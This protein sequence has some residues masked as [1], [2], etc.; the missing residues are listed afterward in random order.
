[1]NRRKFVQSTLSAAALCA[2]AAPAQALAPAI[3]IGSLRR[4]IAPGDGTVLAPGDRGY[5][6]YQRYAAANLRV[7]RSPAAR[8]V[9]T[10]R[11]GAAAAV[12]WL[13]ANGVPFSIRGGGHCYEDF[14]QSDSVVL[15]L[16]GL[17][18][19]KI[20]AGGNTVSVGA[21][22][23][24][25]DTYAALTRTGAIIPAGSC[26]QV[27]VAGHVQGG[28]YGLFARKFGLACDSLVGAE[29]ID[30][31][32]QILSVSESAH[33]DLFWA[34]RGGGG[35]SFGVVT[36]FEFRITKI[37]TATRF[38]ISWGT[39]GRFGLDQAAQTLGAWQAWSHAAPPELTALM[40]V[41]G[42]AGQPV[43]RCFGLSTNTDEA[44]VNR[45]LGLL[46]RATGGT[47]GPAVTQGVADQIKHFAGSTHRLTAPISDTGF[48][49]PVFFKGKSDIVTSFPAAAAKALVSA[50]AN[51][52]SVVAICDPYGGAIAGVADDATAFAHRSRTLFNIQYYTEWTAPG[53]AEQQRRLASMSSVYG[54]MTPFRTGGAYVNYCDRDLGQGFA[55]AY[56]GANLLRLKT[57]KAAYDP[58]NLFR[59]AQS[60][61]I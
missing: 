43:L 17:A 46:A 10:T 22:A 2:M 18:D 42:S 36:R 48:F 1:M 52:G 7:A 38:S 23:L 49:N 26:P 11:E 40:L 27:G 44:W 33:S 37:A 16:R 30:A 56:W 5:A 54:A 3:P 24:L 9:I 12:D 58:R 19:I 51:A 14:S 57:I 41:S 21:G 25:G 4:A 28:G 47:I 50:V 39:R 31:K 6:A 45:E 20:A 53:S 32:G 61:P 15:D 59:H 13:G 29:V 34:L 35:G 55:P 60:V 8:V